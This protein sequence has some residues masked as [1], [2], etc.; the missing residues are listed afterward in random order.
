MGLYQIKGDAL[1]KIV[2]DALSVGYRL[3]GILI[4]ADS[5]SVYRTEAQL[6]IVLGDAIKHGQVTREDIFISDKIGYFV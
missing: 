4:N 1:G 5:A 3:F 6:G 2:T